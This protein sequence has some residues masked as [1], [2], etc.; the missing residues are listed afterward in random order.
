MAKNTFAYALFPLLLLLSLSYVYSQVIEKDSMKNPPRNNEGIEHSSLPQGFSDIVL[1]DT[2]ESVLKKLDNHMFFYKPDEADVTLLPSTK[3]QIIE[4]VGKRFIKKALLQFDS[5]LKLVVITLY[6]DTNVVDYFS[7]YTTHEKKYG[8]AKEISPAFATWEGNNVI[9]LLEKPLQV[10]YIY[11]E[12][13]ASSGAIPTGKQ[14]SETR[15]QERDEFL[16]FF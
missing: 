1:Q 15:S 6:L 13:I 7:I 9:L 5:T 16:S 2:K 10:K 4:I 14:K 12:N 11:V 3:D 8:R